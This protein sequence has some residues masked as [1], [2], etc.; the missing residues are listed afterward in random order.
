MWL[1]HPINPSKYKIVR[2]FDLIVAIAKVMRGCHF[3]YVSAPNHAIYGITE[4]SSTI[5][6]VLIPPNLEVTASFMFRVDT[7]DKDILNKYV[8]FA[9]LDDIP[10]ALFP[11]IKHDEF[12]DYSPL[13]KPVTEYKLWT[14]INIRTRLEIEF[15]D[16]YGVEGIKTTHFAEVQRLLSGFLATRICIGPPK[17]FT[18]MERHLILRD[19]F[20]SKASMGEQYLPLKYIDRDYSIFLSKTLFTFNKN[21]LLTVT[22]RD[23]LDQPQLFEICFSVTHDK[24]PIK[25]VIDGDF[26]ENTYATF[27]RIK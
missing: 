13:F 4:D 27:V 17:V 6:E 24:N 22:V 10:W 3:Y 14:V 26:I 25:F 11:L 20:S 21:D 19:V 16:L 12:C 23:R 9:L 7:V 2:R 1:S 8:D 18:H 15:L 5:R